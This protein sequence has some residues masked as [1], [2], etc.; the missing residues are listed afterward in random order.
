[1]IKRPKVQASPTWPGLDTLSLDDIPEAVDTSRNDVSS[2]VYYV[3]KDPKTL[4]PALL[5]DPA[6]V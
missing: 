4:D 1:M 5:E 3:R 2:F 6:A